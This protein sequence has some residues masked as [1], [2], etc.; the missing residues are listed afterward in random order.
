MKING[1]IKI[2]TYLIILL[3]VSFLLR[4]SYGQDNAKSYMPVT[5]SSVKILDLY[6]QSLKAM[7]AGNTRFNFL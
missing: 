7:E 1:E 6:N 5:A 2:K 3:F 4:N